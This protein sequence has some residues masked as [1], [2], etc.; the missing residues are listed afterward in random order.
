MFCIKIKTKLH[1]YFDS[2]YNLESIKRLC[3]TSP[4]VQCSRTHYVDHHEP[5][6]YLLFVLFFSTCHIA[7]QLGMSGDSSVTKFPHPPLSC[8]KNA[9]SHCVLITHSPS[10]GGGCGVWVWVW[11]CVRGWV[12][13][14]VWGCGVWGC[15]G[16]CGC[17]AFGSLDAYLTC[18][19]RF[20]VTVFRCLVKC[21][22]TIK[23]YFKA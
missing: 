7:R 12:V 23:I 17:S 5:G 21:W 1:P 16:V 8:M 9:L 18:F 6:R 3:C 2:N 15:M 20:F 13:C 11:M 22:V 4:R 14:G 10:V 19:H